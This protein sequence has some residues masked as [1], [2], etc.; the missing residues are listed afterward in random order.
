MR[1]VPRERFVLPDDIPFA[2]VDSALKI[3]C[4]QTISQ[5]SLVL[6]MTELLAL[7]PGEKV[8]EIGTGSGYQTAILAELGYV[9]VYSVEIIPELAR[10]AARRLAALGYGHVHLHLGDGYKGW[11]EHAP[12]EAIIVTAAPDHIPPPL[13]EQLADGGRL[14]IPVGPPRRGQTLFRIVKREEEVIITHRYPVA[15]VPLTRPDGFPSSGAR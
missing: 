10:A 7:S 5:P 2:Y 8:L 3:D 13:L 15:F 12:Y 6:R 4:G 11:P 14:V 1:T 9:E